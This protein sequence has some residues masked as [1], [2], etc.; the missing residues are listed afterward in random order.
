MIIRAT[1]ITVRVV[2]GALL[3]AT[4]A[5]VHAEVVSI[6]CAGGF[7]CYE[8]SGQITQKDSTTIVAI[9]DR[10]IKKRQWNNIFHLD[11]EGGDVDAAIAI[12]RQLRRLRAIAGVGTDDD[13][14]SACIFI[15]AGATRR[16]LSST[17]RIGIHR[18]Y[19]LRTDA[20]DY[21]AVQREH[22]R[23]A[24]AVKIYLAEMNLPIALYDAM[25]QIPPESVRLLTQRELQ[26]FGLGETD[27]VE[28]E[29]MDAS[30]ARKYGLDKLEY[31]Q[32]KAEL[33]NVCSNAWSVG[34]STG[35]FADYFACKERLM[36]GDAP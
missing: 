16:L 4:T 1:K 3:A 2:A 11:S 25:I 32:R 35:D 34:Q 5:I 7:D 10:A 19:S 8:V 24:T 23:L 14:L 18:P 13:C 26:S 30:E 29:L 22:S 27:P 31:M 33:S 36:R 20:R 21:D 28:Q 6:Q 15:L 17:A 9:V 12:G